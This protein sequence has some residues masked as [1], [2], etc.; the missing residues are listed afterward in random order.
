M[1]DM[2]ENKKEIAILLDGNNFY[3]GLEKSSLFSKFNLNLFDYEK[4]VD[5]IAAGREVKIK[6]YYRGLIRKEIGNLKS[7]RM[8]SE[9]QRLFSKL[10]KN[11]WVVKKGRMSK[12]IEFGQCEGFYFLDEVINN[13]KLKKISDEILKEHQY[14]YRP[15]I[16]LARNASNWSLLKQSFNKISDDGKGLKALSGVY[17][18]LN[19]WREK[20]VDVNM[21]IDMLT[22]AYQG[23]VN[24][25][26]KNPLLEK[27]IHYSAEQNNLTDIIVI[28]NDSDLMPAVEKVK[29]IGIN[30]EYVGFAH[31]YSIALLNAANKRLLLTEEQ[32]K[33]FFPQSLI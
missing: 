20:G 4:L 33:E 2:E 6:L 27:I 16:I 11:G 15:I 28:S 5:F 26:L 30:V 31:T 3:K 9:Q 23:K 12:N 8:A 1:E 32:L 18:A 10:E 22:L 14:H 13:K 19:R 17:F 7:G 29:D 24:S 21:A 25:L